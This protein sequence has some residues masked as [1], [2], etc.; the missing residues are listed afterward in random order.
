M[1]IWNGKSEDYSSL[2]VFGC[3][4]YVMLNYQ[5]RTKLDPK[6]KKCIFLSYANSV[7]EYRLWDPTAR[8]VIV[9]RDMIFT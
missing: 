9:S 3:P 5:E 1:E 8:K 7:K 2:H 6:S 4:V